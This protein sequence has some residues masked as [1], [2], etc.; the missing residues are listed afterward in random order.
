MTFPA[1]SIHGIRVVGVGDLLTHAVPTDADVRVMD[2]FT[3]VC[4]RQ[5]A[6]HRLVAVGD[7]VREAPMTTEQRSHVLELFKR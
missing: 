2:G 4:T 3:L 6:V 1:P 5:G 7:E